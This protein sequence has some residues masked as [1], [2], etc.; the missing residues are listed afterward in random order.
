MEQQNFLQRPGGLGPMPGLK[1]LG[2]AMA[3]PAS[4]MNDN[5]SI[6]ARRAAY[7]DDVN[8]IFAQYNIDHGSYARTPVDALPY[9]QGN[10]TKS[11]E[12][13]GPAGYNHQQ[14]PLPERPVDMSPEQYVMEETNNFDPVMR[15][16]V[17]ALTLMP[18]QNFYNNRTVDSQMP[19]VDY[20][21]G[22]DLTYTEP[23]NAKK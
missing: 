4:Y 16:N 5:I 19:L 21:T 8:R 13:N 11:P 18:Q 7:T 17:K 2:M 1:P 15:Q 22:D 14:M 6:S 9:A 10:I 23:T 12:V 3:S 20:R